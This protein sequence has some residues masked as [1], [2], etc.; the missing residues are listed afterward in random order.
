[1]EEKELSPCTRRPQSASLN[2]THNTL[3]GF[4]QVCHLSPVL[5]GLAQGLLHKVPQHWLGLPS[6]SASPRTRQGQSQRR[7]GPRRTD[8]TSL[9]RLTGD[10]DGGIGVAI[11]VG[12]RWEEGKQK[13]HP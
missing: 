5:K 2:S 9:T 6:G 3:Y 8:P 12:P 10:V 1:M 13:G 11:A 4:C 7:R